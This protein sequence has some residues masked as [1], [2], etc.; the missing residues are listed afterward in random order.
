[1]VNII[2]IIIP[3]TF[4]T[5]GRHYVKKTIEE[6]TVLLNELFLWTDTVILVTLYS[7]LFLTNL[8]QKIL[9]AIDNSHQ[10][11]TLEISQNQV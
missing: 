9:L 7:I 11:F 4:M 2:I 8:K 1:M 5:W 10:K 3:F 6:D